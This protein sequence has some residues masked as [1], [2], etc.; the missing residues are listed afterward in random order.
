VI[1]GTVFATFCAVS[2]KIGPLTTKILRGVSVPFGMKRQ[3]STYHTKYLSKYWT[4]LHQLLSIGRHM[5]A[6]YKTEI[7]FAVVE[8]TL[9]W[10]LINFGAFL[11]TSKLTVFTLCSGIS[12]QTATSF[13]KC[14][15]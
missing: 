12:K 11:Q 1:K 5:Y 9:L 15:D 3:K 4:E 6:D 8:E 7:I 2:V 13:S 14:T 10:Y